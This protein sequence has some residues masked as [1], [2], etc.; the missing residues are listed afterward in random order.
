MKERLG[1][2]VRD[3]SFSSGGGD[4][5]L[6]VQPVMEQG[7]GEVVMAEKGVGRWWARRL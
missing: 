4:F 1:E 2:E 7:R 3:C 6:P 5:L